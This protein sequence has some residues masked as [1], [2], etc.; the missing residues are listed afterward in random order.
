[1]ALD[2]VYA[3]GG[4]PQVALLGVV[5]WMARGGWRIVSEGKEFR[6]IDGAVMRV[7]SWTEGVKFPQK[8]HTLVS[9][10]SLF[11]GPAI[12]VARKS[13]RFG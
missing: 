9:L 11:R 5:R 13:H 8:S 4:E 10:V 12:V 2:V 3:R 6:E 7:S 1:V